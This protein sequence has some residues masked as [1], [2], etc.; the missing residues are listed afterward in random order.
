[1]ILLYFITTYV[2]LCFIVLLCH[3]VSVVFYDFKQGSM[4]EKILFEWIP[5]INIFHK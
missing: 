1:M 5:C 3:L 2:V 4:E